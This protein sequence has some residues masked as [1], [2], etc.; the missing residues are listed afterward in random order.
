ME[1][2]MET[3]REVKYGIIKVRCREIFLSYWIGYVIKNS[4]MY[5][6]CEQAELAFNKISEYINSL[7]QK[8]ISEKNAAKM[9]EF[10]IEQFFK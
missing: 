7:K 1:I 4:R 8:N 2:K 10:Y 6:T 9:I 5:D 3:I